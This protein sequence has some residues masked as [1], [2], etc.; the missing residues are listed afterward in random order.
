MLLFLDPAG[1]ASY[2]D[3]VHSDDIN[4]ACANSIACPGSSYTMGTRL[5]L[6]KDVTGFV[7]SDD[8][9]ED[10]EPPALF[11]RI[12]MKQHFTNKQALESATTLSCTTGNELSLRS[13]GVEGCAC[14][15]LGM[16]LKYATINERGDTT[17]CEDGSICAEKQIDDANTGLSFSSGKAAQTPDHTKQLPK[18]NSDTFKPKKPSAQQSQ[19][20]LSA[21]VK[22]STNKLSLIGHS[23]TAPI[24]LD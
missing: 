11:E 5:N 8:D 15:K 14:E 10:K 20:S 7:S 12:K 21:G 1:H 23:A 18:Y 6:G 2:E 24:V 17:K 22:E 13:S 9:D 4:T 3:E 16:H 19:T